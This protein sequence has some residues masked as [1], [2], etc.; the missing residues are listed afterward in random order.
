MNVTIYLEDPLA[1]ELS[2][3]SKSSGQN[4]NAIIREAIHEWLEHRKQQQ[5]PE[6][7]L[8]FKG[9]ADF[10][11]FETYRNELQI[12]KEDPLA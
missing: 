4:R 5:W 12:P 1:K 11:A 7:V 3:W 10:P 8:Q 2:H 9:E 6:A